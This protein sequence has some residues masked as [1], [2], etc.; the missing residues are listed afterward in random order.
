MLFGKNKLELDE[1]NIYLLVIKFLN[2]GIF[3]IIFL[4]LWYVYY[5]DNY[6]C[7]KLVY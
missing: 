2:E 1:F 7:V 4:F 5:F 6:V 3:C